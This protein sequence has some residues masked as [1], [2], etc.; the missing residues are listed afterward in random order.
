[1]KT[2]VLISRVL[3]GFLYLVFGLDY[4]LHFIP[5]QPPLHSGAA[6]EFKAGL[7]ATGYF[8]PMQKT[9]QI[10]GGLSLLINRY[11]PFSAVVLF[12]I[13]LNV[14]L[15]H[16]ILVPSG[17]LMGVFLLVPNLLL[18]YGYRKYYAPMFTVKPLL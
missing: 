6:G 13:S 15:F 4:F 11:A 5:Y 14:F 3:L 7:M 1:M 17:W 8:Y 16:T 9:I 12:P 18:G 2:T 10:L